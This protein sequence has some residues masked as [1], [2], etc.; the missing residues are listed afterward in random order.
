[1]A[2]CVR[3]PREAALVAAGGVRIEDPEHPGASWLLPTSSRRVRRRF[4]EAA[5]TRE[6]RL[7]EVLRRARA[8]LVVLD[9]ATSPLHP[10][11][12]FLHERA[13]RRARSVA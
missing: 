4:R 7:A 2:A 1:V 6:S 10:L 13:R 12:R 3:D 11:A 8:D 5:L 9:T